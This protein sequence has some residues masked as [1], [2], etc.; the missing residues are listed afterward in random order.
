MLLSGIIQKIFK[1][2]LLVRHDPDGTIF[3]F[4][5]EELGLSYTHFDFEG[6]RGQLLRGAFY[7]KNLTRPDTLIVFEHGM[8]CGHR[9]YMREIDLLC[10]R[11]FLVF[12]YDHTG[13]LMS[14][15]ENIGGFSQSLADLDFALAALKESGYTEGRRVSVI[16][17]SWGGF[18]TL[19]IA[20]LHPWLSS[21]VALSG[22]VS[23]NEMIISMLGKM[24]KYAPELLALEAER[25]GSY[26][27]ADARFSLSAARDTRALIIH[28]KDDPICPFSHFE[29]LAAALSGCKSVELCA[30]DGKRHNPNFTRDAVL[31]KDDFFAEMTRRKKRGLL[32]SEGEKAAF[33]S[34]Y[35]WYKMTE[36]DPVL[37]EEIISFIEGEK[38]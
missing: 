1:K 8:G 20:P 32:S 14:E 37:W 18:S 33:I 22:F 11:G 9:A 3:Y 29:K 12:A 30:V 5:P 31:Y 17:H 35:D 16:G 26:S 19:N 36:Q 25:F 27:Y 13:T 24:K 23:V 34:S 7:Q 2:E 4:S 28:S 15:G 21:V 6:D 38:R 10:E